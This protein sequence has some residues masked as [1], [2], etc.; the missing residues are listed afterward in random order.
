M[1]CGPARRRRPLLPNH[2]AALDGGKQR[3]RRSLLRQTDAP[4]IQAAAAHV[5]AGARTIQELV[6]NTLVFLGQ[7]GQSAGSV[8]AGDASALSFL[9]TGNGACFNYSHLFAALMR[10]NGV[11]TRTVS[12]TMRG[13][14]QQMHMIAEYYVPGKGWALVEPQVR[15]LQTDA[16]G[17]LI[18]G[19][20]T[21]ALDRSLERPYYYEYF[22]SDVSSP[23]G[24]VG[25]VAQLGLFVEDSPALHPP[26][27]F[28]T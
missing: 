12:N 19:I 18:T 21:A 25:V 5:R 10:A 8:I 9:Q 2:G 28:A 11:P 4:A 1:A 27:A 24:E 26:F 20:E 15:E 16:A 13:T 22:G 7:L 3:A 23:R 6:D 17:Y 14:A